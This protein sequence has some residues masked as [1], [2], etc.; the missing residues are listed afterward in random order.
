MSP[1]AE[2]KVTAIQGSETRGDYYTHEESVH[3][4]LYLMSDGTVRW[5]EPAADN[6]EEV[7][8]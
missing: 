3:V 2:R 4:T 5:E 6:K 7:A 1:R 8:P